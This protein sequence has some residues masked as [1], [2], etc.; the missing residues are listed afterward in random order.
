[1]PVPLLHQLFTHQAW[2]DSELLRAIAAHPAASSDEKLIA[3]LH[4]IVAVQRIFTA[5]L[6]G[7][8]LD[9]QQERQAVTSLPELQQLYA[10]SHARQ[11][12]FVSELT[13]EA[14]DRP[15]ENPWMPDLKGTVADILMQ[16]ILHSQNHR[17]QCLTRLRELTGNAPTLDF[18]LWVKLGR[19]N[20]AQTAGVGQ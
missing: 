19:P 9:V 15:V 12:A 20:P 5:M 18:I 1:M 2:A 16:V 7:T 8:P 6:T 10:G 17:G 11:L 3:T 4:H 13:A 14:L